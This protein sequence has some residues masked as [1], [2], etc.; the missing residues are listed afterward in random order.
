M[1]KKRSGVTRVAVFGDV[2]GLCFAAMLCA[3]SVVLAF[4]A[5]LIFG[6]G[7]IRFTVENLP[8]Q[9]AGAVWGPFGGALVALT[10]D[11]VSCLF[12]GM[13]PNPLISLGSVTVGVLSGLLLHRRAEK[14]G[15]IR[16]LVASL[17]AHAAGSML[18]KTLALH[19][20]FGYSFLLL[21][22]RIPLY[23]GIAVIE[24]FLVFTLC[25]NTQIRR[26]LRALAGEKGDGA[27][28]YQEAIDYIHSVVWKGSRPG[29]SRITQLLDLLD[30]P[31]NGMKF[32]H[33]AG[34]NG[35]GSVCAMTES[36]L[37]RAG[38]RTGLFVSPYIK[39]FN[40]RIC[41]S[42]APIDDR[43]LAEATAAVRPFADSMADAPTEF[44]LITAIGLVY[45]KRMKCD[46]VVLE[47]GMGGRLDSTNVIKDP[48]ATV[49][50]GIALDHTAYLGDTVEQIAAE[51]AG[52]LKKG[53]PVV[54]G[55]RD[56][57]ARAVIEAR[58][59]EIGVPFLAAED[60]P[61]TVSKADLSGTVVSYG[62]WQDVSIP[63]LGSYQPQ[64]LAT[65]L[66][67]MRALA[68]VGYAI[69]ERAVREGLLAMRWR[70]RFEK[71]CEEP[72]IISDG[73]HNPEGIRAAAK[74]ITAYF[75]EKKVLIL[76]GVMA[77]KDYHDMVN[78][79]AP[80]TAQ[81][82][83]LTPDNPRA[84]PAADLA[85]VFESVGVPATPFASVREAVCAAVQAARERGMPL[86]SLGS[87]YMYAEVTDI[88]EKKGVIRM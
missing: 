10:A 23:I 61:V 58:A 87:L 85:A 55:G 69:D 86:L 36:I 33:V 84:L 11:L 38:Y 44:E 42:G 88:L 63:L 67:L 3:M 8:I 48:I 26:I 12:S 1:R 13:A 43:S 35:K 59:A 41:V 22:P 20:W 45:F 29:L 54:W 24:G 25:R 15:V 16:V 83:V 72:L 82:F 32:I 64:N 4:L 74:G 14:S 52:I 66:T 31:Q 51:K 7:P 5:K 19:L 6:Y 2:K 70:G 9:L 77:D 37:R 30:N 62:E 53:A 81:A 47:T 18:V 34:T 75:G 73:A 78:V 40:E 79:L 27:M 80:H 21:W 57:A 71:L 28:T 60:T 17:S 76:T 49:I 65:V 46:V 50:T 68:T 56:A 39:H